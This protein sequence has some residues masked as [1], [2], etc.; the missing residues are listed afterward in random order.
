MAD[1]AYLDIHNDRNNAFDDLYWWLVCPFML[2]FFLLIL[3][4]CPFYL[5][6]LLALFF[7]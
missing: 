4:T 3:F 1:L 2:A 5:S 7:T 6:F